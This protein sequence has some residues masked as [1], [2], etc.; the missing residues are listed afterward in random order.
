MHGHDFDVA[1]NDHR[2]KR[3]ELLARSADHLIVVSNSLKKNLNRKQ[4][5]VMST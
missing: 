5:R 1:L 2:A 4:S 3:I